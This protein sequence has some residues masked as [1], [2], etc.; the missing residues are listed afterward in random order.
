MP[1]GIF[2]S[3]LNK[4]LTFKTKSTFNIDHTC[5]YFVKCFGKTCRSW[6]IAFLYSPIILSR[7]IKSF[8]TTTTTLKFLTEQNFLRQSRAISTPFSNFSVKETQLSWRSLL[9]I[10]ANFGQNSDSGIPL[11][12]EISIVMSGQIANC[13]VPQVRVEDALESGCCVHNFVNV[14]TCWHAESPPNCPGDVETETLKRQY[15]RNL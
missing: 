6:V 4:F 8:T 11:G 1:L 13:L 3:A 9:E 7:G 15:Y 12:V 2:K 14:D 10:W 5:S